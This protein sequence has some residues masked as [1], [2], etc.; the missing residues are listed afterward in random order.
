MFIMNNKTL[1]IDDFA[2]HVA[3]DEH[4]RQLQNTWKL[5]FLLCRQRALGKHSHV[6]VMSVP[7]H[8]NI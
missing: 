4:V 6:S 1:V 8:L 2:Y 3:N 5:E 7:S